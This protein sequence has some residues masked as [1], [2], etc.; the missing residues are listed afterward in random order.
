M[1]KFFP[2]KKR[3][4]N[5]G[6]FLSIGLEMLTACISLIMA[7]HMKLSGFV[8]Q[9]NGAI[10]GVVVAGIFQLLFP[11]HRSHILAHKFPIFLQNLGC[12]GF[13]SH[14]KRILF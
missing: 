11:T 8:G 9:L 14:E 7:A 2:E 12:W 4:W 10:V 5:E 6:A 3:G 13:F 1:L